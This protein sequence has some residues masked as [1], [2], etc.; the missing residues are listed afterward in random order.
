MVFQHWAEAAGTADLASPLT[1]RPGT[2]KSFPTTFD[3]LD[4]LWQLEK[5]LLEPPQESVSEEMGP[6]LGARATANETL[7]RIEGDTFS[8]EEE[9]ARG[10][11]VNMVRSC[12]Q[13]SLALKQALQDESIDPYEMKG[14]LRNL[15]RC[16]DGGVR[17]F[18]LRRALAGV[19]RP[20]PK[21]KEGSS[22][23]RQL[24]IGQEAPFSFHGQLPGDAQQKINAM[25]PLSSHRL[26]RQEIFTSPSRRT[27]LRVSEVGHPA[28]GGPWEEAS[29]A[30][31]T[32]AEKAG[33][34]AS[35]PGD[36]AHLLTEAGHCLAQLGRAMVMT[37]V[38]LGSMSP[39]AAAF[40]APIVFQDSNPRRRT[41]RQFL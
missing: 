37:P 6:E 38:R 36:A 30:C 18:G 31:D 22:L 14:I 24:F 27:R 7:P 32:A 23:V 41:L 11:A 13:S 21:E 16:S 9:P 8:L 5:K 3:S 20:W 26:R 2:V 39:T 29:S 10:Q 40:V 25:K 35:T 28:G 4:D 19:G 15:G 1:A 33:A 12:L 34:A 17:V